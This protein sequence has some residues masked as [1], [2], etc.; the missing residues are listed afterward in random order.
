MLG[1]E[2]EAGFGEAVH[3]PPDETIGGDDDRGH[4]EG[5]CNQEREVAFVGGMTDGRAESD[6]LVDLTAEMK[7]LGNDTGVPCAPGSGDQAGD[8]VGKDCG[9]NQL[10]PALPAVDSEDLGSFFQV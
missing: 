7:V 10:A 1:V 4:G 8:E 2:A 6:G 5:G 3:L 9:Q